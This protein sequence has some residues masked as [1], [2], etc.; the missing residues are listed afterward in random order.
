MCAE[1]IS[2]SAH[3]W[4]L[5]GDQTEPVASVVPMPT[6]HSIRKTDRAVVCS[7]QCY[8]YY[9]ELLADTSGISQVGSA[10]LCETR[11]APAHPSLRD[12]GMERYMVYLFI[13]L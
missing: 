4:L 12:K 3:V 6:Q 7:S 5:C 2:G 13:P 1:S 10:M 8:A 11:C 9:A